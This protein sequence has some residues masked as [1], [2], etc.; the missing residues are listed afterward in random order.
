[1]CAPLFVDGEHLMDPTQLNFD[2]ESMRLAAGIGLLVLSAFCGHLLLLQDGHRHVRVPLA[3]FFWANAIELLALPVSI[4]SLGSTLPLLNLALELAEVP[5]TMAKPFLLWLYVHR[6]TCDP[7]Q[8]SEQPR[9]RWHAM[10]IVFACIVYLYVLVL[11]AE[12]KASLYP[13]APDHVVWQ[14]I[15]FAGLYAATALFYVLVPIYAI[16]IM[17]RLRQYRT[18]LKDLFASTEGREMAW[19]RW[20]AAAVIVFWCFN[21][22]PIVASLAEFSF[23]GAAV[24]DSLVAMIIVQYALIWSIALWGT[25]QRP[26]ITPSPKSDTPVPEETEPQ[27]KYGKSGLSEMRLDRIANKID[28]LMSEQKLYLEPDLSLWDLAGRIGVTTHYASQALNEKIG[29]RFF[30]YI[31]GWR[32]RD[33]AERLRTTDATIL[34][35][36]YDVGFNSRSSF[37]TAFKRELGVTPSQYR[38]SG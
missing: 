18:R 20:L 4:L 32:I 16:L 10:P 5:L 9:W 28:T 21:L 35:I 25:R 17:L 3:L 11:P 34:V 38:A 33:A 29:I 27:R 31:N 22:I 19:A 23:P 1:M 12:L 15:A 26:G 30:D 14:T 7:T 13:D 8:H 36:A 6:L 2:I 24:F 37:Y